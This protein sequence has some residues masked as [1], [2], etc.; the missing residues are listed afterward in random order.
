MDL[1][2]RT[3]RLADDSSA[4]P[5][6]EDPPAGPGAA[7]ED[8]QALALLDLETFKAAS[9]EFRFRLLADDN[10]RLFAESGG[11]AGLR[12][13][14]RRVG[15][16][17]D[18]YRT[19]GI[20]PG[21]ILDAPEKI[22]R[23]QTLIARQLEEGA[24]STPQS[25]LGFVDEMLAFA[26]DRKRDADRAQLAALSAVLFAFN[27]DFPAYTRLQDWDR[28]AHWHF[29]VPRPD[30]GYHH[31]RLPRSTEEACVAALAERH[32]EE[33]LLQRQELSRHRMGSVTQI[34]ALRRGM[35][36]F[37]SNLESGSWREAFETLRA[38]RGHFGSN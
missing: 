20:W 29:F 34:G 3:Y 6:R 14:A 11:F 19:K 15:P 8:A 37:W 33:L 13:E 38:L 18:F 22:E 1:K 7:T 4:V 36:D 24:G 12:A 25:W 21:Q 30:R 35:L 9:E 26:L 16:V 31:F 10:Y 23:A 28:D 5:A 2:A 32:L 17:G 27:Q